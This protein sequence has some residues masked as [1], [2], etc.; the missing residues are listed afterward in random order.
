ME[1]WRPSHQ[2]AADKQ[3]RR[4][5]VK[6]DSG[7]VFNLPPSQHEDNQQEQDVVTAGYKNRMQS[8][9]ASTDPS[10]ACPQT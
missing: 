7:N 8:N 1:G 6:E 9:S 4:A 5:V 10:A 2:S 3:Q